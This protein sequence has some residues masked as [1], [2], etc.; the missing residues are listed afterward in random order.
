MCRTVP[1]AGAGSSRGPGHGPDALMTLRELRSPLACYQDALGCTSQTSRLRRA[2]GAL[3]GKKSQFHRMRHRGRARTLSAL[4]APRAP[5]TSRVLPIQGL[6]PWDQLCL[7]VPAPVSHSDRETPQHLLL[8]SQEALP[9]KPQQISQESPWPAL[10]H[11]AP[12]TR[13]GPHAWSHH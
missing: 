6:M 10:G 2:P 13:S 5:W 3:T 1:G 9:Q 8:R 7:G 11:V 4:P 12:A